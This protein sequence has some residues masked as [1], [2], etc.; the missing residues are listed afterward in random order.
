MRRWLRRISI[1]LGVLAALLVLLVIVVQI[2]LWTPL[3]R[4]IAIGL[5]EKQLGLRIATSKLSI[6]W[7]GSTELD[8]VTLGLPMA[9]DSFL[10]VKSLKVKNTSLIGLALG[11]AISIDSIAID[12]PNIYV[13]QNA[14]GD[15]NLQQVATLLGKALGSNTATESNASKG[16]PKLPN[17]RVT[18][19]V[20]HVVDNRHRT[21]DLG[22]LNVTGDSDGAL[23]WKYDAKVADSIHVTGELAPGGNWLHKVK[24]DAHDLEPLVA[25]YKLP[26]YGATVKAT[27]TGQASDGKVTGTLVIGTAS[28]KGLPQIGDVSASGA[29]ELEVAGGAVTAHPRKLVI[30]TPLVALP[31]LTFD[32][33]SLSSDPGGVHVKGVRLAALGGQSE[34][35]ADFDPAAMAGD[36]KADWAGLSLENKTSRGGVLTASLRMPFPNQPAMKFSLKSNGTIG[37]AVTDLGARADTWAVD[38]ELAGQGT[39]W[40]DIDWVLAAPTLEYDTGGK[41]YSLANLAAQISERVPA[42]KTAPVVKLTDFSVPATKVSGLISDVAISSSGQFDLNGNKPWRAAFSLGLKA[43]VDGVQVPVTMELKADGEVGVQPKCDLKRFVVTVADT[44]L[45]ATGSYDEKR[46]PGV[47]MSPAPV[48]LHLDLSETPRLAE[49]APVKGTLNGSFDI[50]GVLFKADPA[51]PGQQLW[52]PYLKIDGQLVSNDLVVLKHPIGD[53]AIKLTGDV[54]TPEHPDGSPSRAETHIVSTEFYLLNAPWSLAVNYPNATNG[55]EVLLKT[56]NLSVADLAKVADQTGIAGRVAAATWSAVIY[57]PSIDRIDFRSD[58]HL[59]GVAAAGLVAD[60]IDATASIHEG[61]LTV[62]PVVAKFGTG[63]TD[64]SA[65]MN[66][67]THQHLLATAS[68]KNWPDK[69]SDLV[70]ARASANAEID[71]DLEH[72]RARATVTA[73]ADLFL[74]NGI[75][76]L[77]LA[78][79]DL[80]AAMN[81]RLITLSSL[82]GHVLDGPFSGSGRFDLDKPLEAFARFQWQNVDI[83]KLVPLNPKQ[84]DGLSGIYSGTIVMAPAVNVEARPIGPVRI[85][86]NVAT[87]DAKYRTVQ[88]GGRGLLAFHG[89]AYV[90]SDRVVLDH[91][92]LF[93]AGGRAHIWARL[94]NGLSSKTL[95]LNLDNLQLDQLAHVAPNVKGPMPGSLTGRFGLVSSGSSLTQLVGEG[96]VDLTQTDLGNLGPI[97]ALYNA[98]HIGGGTQPTGSGSVDMTVEQGTLRITSFKYFNRGLDAHGLMVV[99]PFDFDEPMQTPISGQVVGSLRA[100][101]DTRIPLLSDFDQFASV[102]QRNLTSIDIGRNLADPTYTQSGLA[103]LGTAM[104]QLLVGDAEASKA[105]EKGR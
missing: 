1:A 41:A 80:A 86:I 81:N 104:Q 44:T 18:D 63:E 60:T 67:H 65:S 74:K 37:T 20:V 9:A 71:L 102:L 50:V 58:Y 69:I 48:A 12:R 59:T 49:D 51:Q 31:T 96:H 23:L 68:V 8:D 61:N 33:G 78:H 47:K 70:E 21:A 46:T 62:G 56:K 93:I 98:A 36:L 82:S 79:A 43:L 83:G 53:I 11:R 15:W 45:R 6:G 72:P 26:T 4:R 88:I 29:V 75:G 94:S 87:D 3:P 52:H 97:A 40:G 7:F 28:A 85:D 99:G 13:V 10:T 103:G 16:V 2:V 66:L 73:A 25:G 105:S 89:V 35:T 5:V 24:L 27:W 19:G 22:P 77:L 32:A 54:K 95:L 92:T 14:Q 42:G 34:I 30:A 17:I 100:L 84:M 76:S 64:L 101:K 57:G 91:S 90:G 55:I 39:S 38:L